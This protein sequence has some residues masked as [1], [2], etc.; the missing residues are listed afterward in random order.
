MSSRLLLTVRA[1]ALGL[2]IVPTGALAADPK[3]AAPAAPA[4]PS[5]EQVDMAEMMRKAKQFTQPGEAHKLLGRFIGNWTTETRFT[6]PGLTRPPEKGSSSCSWLFEQRWVRCE[7]KGTMMG[8]PMKTFTL[9]G[10]D[11]FKMSYRVMT[12]QDM[13][14]AMNT[15]EG[16][17]D[18]SGKALLTY[19]TIDEYLTGE[20]DKM[21]KYVWRFLSEDKLVLEV[22]D[23]PI[24]ENNNKV[25][26]IAYTRAP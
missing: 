5:P 26:E 18:P 19:G 11:N 20:H 9:L 2:L 1:A 25:F 4:A 3:P 24:G 6:M 16:D 10:Y 12:V 13:D 7:F 8:M 21:V 22:Y 23:L 17:L 15:S 14:T